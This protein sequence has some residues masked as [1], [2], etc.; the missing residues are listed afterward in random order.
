MRLTQWL[1]RKII[2][3]MGNVYVWLD[4][5]LEHPTGPILGVEID[6]DFE[7][8]GRRELC[9]HIEKK[10]GWSED[11]FWNLESTQKIRLCSQQAR[12]MFTMA[13]MNTSGSD[14]SE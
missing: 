6:D 9:R 8:M 10:F 13:D 11:S 12:N 2:S 1:R 3:M 5:G 4:K 14:E 7:A